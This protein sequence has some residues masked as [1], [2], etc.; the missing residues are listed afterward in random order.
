MES[1][2][3]TEYEKQR[4]LKDL[5][6]LNK[7]LVN[8]KKRQERHIRT[9]LSESQKKNLD[10]FRIRLK[11]K[12][13][14]NKKDILKYGDDFTKKIKGTNWDIF[15][16]SLRSLNMD[17]EQFDALDSAINVVNRAIK[18]IESI[19]VNIT[20]WRDMD[21]SQRPKEKSAKITYS[22]DIT[23]FHP[24]IVEASRS[25]FESGHYAQSI[26]EAF[27]TVNNYVKQMT[28]LS[29]DGKA[30]MSKTF[31]EE[32]PLIP[33]N[34]LDTQSKRDEQE[35]F[36]FLFM[37][38]MVGIRNPFAHE[39]YSSFIEPHITLE[40]LGFASLLMGKIDGVRS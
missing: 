31:S 24:N 5:S 34:E 25:L 23:Q 16:Y 22:L 36:K 2:I 17:P 3:I 38:A 12:Y 32:K 33:F 40:Y 26:L 27:K 35:G 6:N 18:N 39:D 28:G 30:L 37:G 15:V 11:D 10:L 8:Y 29:L 19:T 7:D 13:I 14:L 1:L 4:L 21:M 20:D 9:Q